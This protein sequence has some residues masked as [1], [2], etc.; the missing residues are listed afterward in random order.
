MKKT[1]LLCYDIS[2]DKKRKKT[3]DICEKNGERWQ[4]SVFKLVMTEKRKESI[5]DEISKLLEK[6]DS[7]FIIPLEK[8]ILEKGLYFGEV[9]RKLER[10]GPLII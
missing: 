4:Y 8:D 9:K 3:S 2:N 7:L 5:M 10:L 6:G 1:Y